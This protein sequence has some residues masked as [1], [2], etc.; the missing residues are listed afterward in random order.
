MCAIIERIKKMK[1]PTHPKLG[2]ASIAVTKIESEPAAVN[3]VPSC[4]R[5]YVDRRTVLGE[6]AD[7]VILELKKLAEEDARVDVEVEVVKY[8]DT[9]LGAA[10]KYFP[11]WLLP[12]THPLVQKGIETYKLLFGKAPR[13]GIWKFSTDGAYTMGVK[14]IPTIGFGPGDEK[15]AHTAEDQV[16]AAQVVEC[17]MFYALLPA[18][19]AHHL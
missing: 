15:Y 19:I 12:E 18:V 14:N 5:A 17:A 10:E 16:P 13:L 4:C 9:K 6:S 7:V 2:N 3:V 11:A 8:V 1:L